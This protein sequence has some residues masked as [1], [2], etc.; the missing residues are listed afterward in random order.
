MAAIPRKVPRWLIIVAASISSLVVVMGVSL[1]SLYEASQRVPEFYHRALSRP[2]EVQQQARDAFVAQVAALAS[3]LDHPGAWQSLF[4]ADQINAWLA[5]ELTNH[6]PDMLQGDLSDPRLVIRDNEATLACRYESGE[7]A[8]VLSL[9]FD[10]HLHEPNVLALRIRRARAGNVPVP[11]AQVLENINHAAREL[12]LRI[13]WSKS[14]GDPVMLI[15][16][17]ERNPSSGFRLETVELRD[18]EVFLAGSAGSPLQPPA[19]V[20]TAEVDPSAEEPQVELS[21][22]PKETRQE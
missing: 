2:A 19:P 7:M 5:L 3:D 17:D 1:F 8:A 6:Y 11:L 12:K 4:T 13:K 20:T 16:F 18:G 22:A 21:A 10:V 14:H 15:H 9:S